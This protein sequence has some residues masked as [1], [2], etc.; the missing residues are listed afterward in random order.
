MKTI[1]LQFET[2]RLRLIPTSVDDAAFIL[3]LLNSPNWLQYIGDRNVHTLEEALS[4]IQDKMTP[5]LK[6]LGYGN[7]TVC[8]KST[9]QKIGICGLYDRAGLEGIDIGFAFL[10]QFEKNGFAFESAKMVRDLALNQF[11]LNEISAITTEAN[12]AS[13]NLLAKL[14][15]QFEKKFFIKGDAEE[16]M[17]FKMVKETI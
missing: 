13:Q 7:F 9:N 3:E 10:P 4:Y 11:N 16:L 2:E 12:I 17:L 1:P 5:Q 8:L 6:R 14:G 15:F